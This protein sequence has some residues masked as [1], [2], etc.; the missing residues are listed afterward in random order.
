MNR[1]GIRRISLLILILLLIIFIIKYFYPTNYS[2]TNKAE[3][4]NQINFSNENLRLDNKASILMN[5]DTNQI[6]YQKNID[7]PLPVYSVSK[8]MFLATANQYMLEN[9]I[10]FNTK[11]VIDK[12]SAK[13]NTNANFS[14]ANLKAGEKYT[15]KELFQATMLPSGNDATVALAN[16]LFESHSKAVEIMNK[17]AKSWGMTNSSFV[18]TSGL[19][20]EFL[21]DLSIEAKNGKN[22][23]SINNSI[24]LIK[25]I[26]SDYPEIINIGK[27]DKAIIGKNN[28]LEN[29]NLLLNKNGIYGLKTGS[30]NEDYSYNIISLRKDKNNQNIIAISYDSYS[31]KSLMQDIK[32]MYKYL[33]NLKVTNLR[34]GIMIEPQFIYAKNKVELSTKNNF[35]LYHLNNQMFEYQLKPVGSYNYQLNKFTYANKG[36]SVGDLDILDKKQFFDDKVIGLSDIIVANDLIQDN[37][38]ERVLIFIKEFLLK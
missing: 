1:K 38:F 11:V 27:Q 18:T 34:D 36:S 13:L 23:L 28:E 33:D 37:I 20:G 12:E 31:R 24:I 3:I 5:L 14:S 26:M 15:I 19:D 21:K 30:N 9:K 17:N 8:L 6:I 10:S 25:K 7:Q 29:T 32:T 16:Y 22:K 35:Y 2:Y 4:K